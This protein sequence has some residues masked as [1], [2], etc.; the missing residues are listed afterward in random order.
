Q[1][2]C[3]NGNDMDDVQRGFVRPALGQMPHHPAQ[4]TL[5][6]DQH[7]HHILDTA[8]QPTCTQAT[9]P[10]WQARAPGSRGIAAP[11][12]QYTTTLLM[13]SPECIR[14]KPLLMSSSFRIWVIIGSISI[15]PSIYQSTMPG[16]SEEH[17]SELQSRENL[18]CR[19]LLEKKKEVR[20]WSCQRIDEHARS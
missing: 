12:P 3:R 19:L 2:A 16:R 17:T 18:V 10:F 1:I 5:P 14:S 9:G 20:D 4:V 7:L 8:V 15:L 13:L 11:A 6:G